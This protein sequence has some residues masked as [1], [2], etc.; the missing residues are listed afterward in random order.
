MTIPQL[1]KRYQEA[2]REAGNAFVLGDE[3][4]EMQWIDVRNALGN[5]L[6]ERDYQAWNVLRPRRAPAAA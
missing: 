1:Q 5:I 2:D 6:R 3:R 4:L